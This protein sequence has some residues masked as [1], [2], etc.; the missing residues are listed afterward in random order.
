MINV[1]AQ[2]TPMSAY[3]NRGGE[4]NNETLGM[5]AEKVICDICC[6]DSSLIAHRSNPGYEVVLRPYVERSLIDL[7]PIL[8]HVGTERGDRG[9]QSK[10]AVD[11][12]CKDGKTLSVKTTKGSWKLCPS[13]CGQ[14]GA[15]TF[16]RY[17]GHLYEG[18]INPLKFK[19]LVLEKIDQMIPIYLKH[20]FDC[21]FMLYLYTGKKSGHFI[22]RKSEI[23][24]LIWDIERFSF[25]KNIVTWNESCTVKYDG[26][27]IGE[28]Q[29]HKHRSPYK[30]RF[31]IR[32]L[33][34][35][36]EAKREL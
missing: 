13:E 8:K 28:F 33:H 7:P 21:D 29:V 10:S 12:I 24:S 32:N 3:N 31:E 16:D 4:I 27:S 11:F 36:I 20:T 15:E 6:I 22:F 30:F 2:A 19:Q 1:T 25:T 9:G 35:L 5:T 17:F 34:G 14:P 18:Q 23:P 26:I